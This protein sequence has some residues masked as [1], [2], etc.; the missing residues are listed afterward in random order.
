VKRIELIVTK[1]VQTAKGCL[2]YFGVLWITS[3][4]NSKIPNLAG[5]VNRKIKDFGFG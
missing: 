5:L 3:A 2:L 4:I 1:V